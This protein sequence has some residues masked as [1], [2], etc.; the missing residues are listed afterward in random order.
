[1]YIPADSVLLAPHHQGNLAVGLQADQAVDHVTACLLEHFRPLD[2]ILLIKA[3]LQ[4]HECRHL[5][6]VFGCMRKRGNDRRMPG[7]T[8]ERHLDRKNIRINRRCAD[9]VHDRVKGLVRMGQ[10]DIS[11]PDHREQIL[12]LVA[13]DHR[14]RL[15]RPWTVLQP[16]G[17][18]QRIE[19]HQV[20]QIKRSGDRIHL[21]VAHIKLAAKDLKQLCIH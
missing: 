12:P 1:M 7:H 6:S 14:I 20:S 3:G 4:F 9:Q 5:F 11:L 8:V 17:A 2:I 19:P 16:V 13:C 10:E 18:R 21:H 15:G